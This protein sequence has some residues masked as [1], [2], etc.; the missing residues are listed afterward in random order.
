VLPQHGVRA[1]RRR[2][3]AAVLLQRG[4]SG[5]EACGDSASGGVEAWVSRPAAG[6]TW[7]S[8]C[9]TEQMKRF[10]F[11]ADMLRCEPLLNLPRLGYVPTLPS[12]A[13]QKQGCIQL[14]LVLL[15]FFS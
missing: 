9:R 14:C 12:L 10:S 6:G 15:P 5:V 4:A 7:A 2:P 11:Y 1:L 3:E 8:G 13:R